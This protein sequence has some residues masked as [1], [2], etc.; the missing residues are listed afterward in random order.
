MG[1]TQVAFLAGAGSD[2]GRWNGISVCRAGDAVALREGVANP[3][4]CLFCVE[5]RLEG[6]GTSV[7][8]GEDFKKPA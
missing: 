1:Q 7:I 8:F 6:F 4:I 3:A 5:D 2:G